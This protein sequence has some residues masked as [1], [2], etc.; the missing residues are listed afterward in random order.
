MKYIEFTL[1][2]KDYF[3]HVITKST[4]TL[5]DLA[6]EDLNDILLDPNSETD[7][8]FY[9]NYYVDDT[10]GY[11]VDIDYEIYLQNKDG[12][13]FKLLVND[14]TILKYLVKMNVIETK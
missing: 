3:G 4:E 5:A 12:K 14:R 6:P 8:K 10:Y 9:F 13:E 2:H 1:Q 11:Q 7:F